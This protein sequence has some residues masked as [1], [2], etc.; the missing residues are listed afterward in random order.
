M[1]KSKRKLVIGLAGGIGS[2]KSTVARLLGEHGVRVIDSDRLNHEELATPPVIEKLV[3]WFGESVR[4]SDG[5]IRREALARLVFDDPQ[6][7]ARVEGLLHPRIDRRRQVL[8]DEGNEDPSVRAIAIDSPLLYEAGLDA[9]CDVVIF[10]DAPREQRE[11]RVRAQRGWPAEEL[12]RRE[13]LQKPLDSKRARADHTVVNDSGLD[14]L[15]H[16]VEELLSELLN[17]GT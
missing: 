4:A 11:R 8:I 12:A 14:N 10:V 13:K 9:A 7:R 15:R 1:A 6:A 16:R 5:S 2:G 3:G 17:E